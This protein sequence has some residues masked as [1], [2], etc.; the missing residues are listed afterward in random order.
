M[1]CYPEP[2]SHIRNKVKVVVDLSIYGTMKEL[3]HATGI[4]ACGL[5]A[6]TD[7]VGLKAEI[8]KLDIN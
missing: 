6:K 8:D 1:N 2:G 7:F 5:V 4:G 3:N